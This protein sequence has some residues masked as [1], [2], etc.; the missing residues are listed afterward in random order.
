MQG[1][2]D[3]VAKRGAIFAITYMGKFTDLGQNLKDAVL[4]IRT[5]GDQTVAG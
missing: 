5:E 1:Y 2:P 4:S 3:P